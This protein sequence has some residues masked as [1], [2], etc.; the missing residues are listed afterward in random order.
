MP[1]PIHSQ[2]I[3]I[4]SILVIVALMMAVTVFI[5]KWLSPIKPSLGPKHII[6]A[7]KAHIHRDCFRHLS[8]ISST[9]FFESMLQQDLQAKRIKDHQH[10][11]LTIPIAYG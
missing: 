9:V 2:I 1:Q 10:Q 3:V 11:L 5:R 8:P 7:L 4:D 6:T